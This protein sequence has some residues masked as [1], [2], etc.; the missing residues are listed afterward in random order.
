MSEDPATDERTTDAPP[1]PETTTAY[2]LPALEAEYG[3]RSVRRERFEVSGDRYETVRDQHES[4]ELGGARVLV[5]RPDDRA[6]LLVSNRGEFGWDIPGGAREAGETP[7][8]TAVRECFEE[9]NTRVRL[10]DLLRIHEFGFVPEAGDARVAGLWLHFQGV[11]VAD[12]P[13]DTQEEE[14]AEATWTSEPPERLDRYAAPIVRAYLGRSSN[15][16]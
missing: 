14:I 1:T 15:W 5:C 3:T 4:G 12:T 10:C 13:L 7:E 11:A 16:V 8:E 2:D 6:T 9:T